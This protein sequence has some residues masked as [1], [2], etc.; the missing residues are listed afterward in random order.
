VVCV[1]A[2]FERTVERINVL[3]SCKIDNYTALLLLLGKKAITCLLSASAHELVSRALR[4]VWVLLT[5]SV[6][7]IAIFLISSR[8]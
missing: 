7:T 3:D 8:S 2:A 1:R 6:D 4:D 5:T